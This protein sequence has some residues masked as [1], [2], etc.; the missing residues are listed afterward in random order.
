MGGVPGDGG[1]GSAKS[2]RRLNPRQRK[3][4]AQARVAPALPAAAAA[5]ASMGVA[6]AGAEQGQRG[7]K[8]KAPGGGGAAQRGGGTPA[9]KRRASPSLPSPS[10]SRSRSRVPPSEARDPSEMYLEAPLRA[11]LVAEAR[12]FFGALGLG[13]D[14][15][16]VRVGPTAGWRT[17]AKLA[18][19]AGPG[20]EKGA[21]CVGL[22][23]PGSHD[24]VDLPS[25]PA[26]HPAVNA[27]VAEVKAGCA[28]VRAAGYEDVSGEGELRYLCVNVE[29]HSGKVQVGL[30]WNCEGRGAAGPALGA[31]VAYLVESQ[32]RGTMALH[33]VWVNYHAPWKHSNAIFS[34]E[35]GAW[36]LRHG[37]GEVEERLRVRGCDLGVV[38]RFNPTV[39]RQAN[40]DAFAHVVSSVRRWVGEARAGRGGKG[41]QGREPP[42]LLELYGG[43]GTIGLHAVDLVRSYV[44]SDENPSNAACF[45][46]AAAGLPQAVLRRHRGGGTLRYVQEGASAMVASG[47]HLRADVCVVDPPRKGLSDDV[48]AALRE[49]RDAEGAAAPLRRLIYVSC[50][51]K[52]FRRDHRAL[53]AGGHWSLV[54]AE[55]HVLFPGADQLET[56]AV[57]DRAPA[58]DGGQDDDGFEWRI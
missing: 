30:V 10:P 46:A 42:R 48:V 13:R 25:C 44:C 37:P 28:A 4:L 19:R 21:V 29:R 31:L 24:L 36:E 14:A 40:L 1:G 55:G 39:F 38:L 33:S 18:V 16:Q 56:L 26:H 35:P 9:G 34:R 7:T 22:F 20:G 12:Q 41:A 15:F 17:H 11:P 58:L 50:G 8:R 47:A 49:A 43:V 45:E 5:A 2:F 23:R 27:A 54:H 6:A 3:K 53:T 52:A 51:F 57:F 32:S